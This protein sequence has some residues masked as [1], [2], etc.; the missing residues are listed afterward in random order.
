MAVYPFIC[1]DCFRSATDTEIVVEKENS[2]VVQHH[3]P[4]CGETIGQKEYTKSSERV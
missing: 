4:E 3:C 1:P 2:H